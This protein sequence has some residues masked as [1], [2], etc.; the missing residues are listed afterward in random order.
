M[1][2]PNFVPVSLRLSRSTHSSMVS[3]SAATSTCLPL[4]VMSIASPPHRAPDRSAAFEW[5]GRFSAISSRSTTLPVRRPRW[6]LAVDAHRGDPV[7][8]ELDPEP[9][10][11]GHG[12]LAVFR[13]DGSGHHVGGQRT[14]HS[15]GKH[16]L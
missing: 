4:T 10:P 9:G 15:H 11:R 16:T 7:H 5:W 6:R 13:H 8:V 1:P 14:A 12:D 2:H 3:G